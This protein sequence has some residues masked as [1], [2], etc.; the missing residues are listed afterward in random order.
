MEASYGHVRDLPDGA[1]DVPKDLRDQEWAALGVDVANG[2]KPLYVVSPEKQKRVAALK[3]A[4][5][6]CDAL[7]LAT[8]GD[9]E[10]EAIA[11]HLVELLQPKVPVYRLVFHEITRTAIE[12]ALKNA[13]SIDADLVHAQETRRIVDRLVGYKVSPLLWHKIAYGLSAGRVQ[14]VALRLPDNRVTRQPGMLG[15]VLENAVQCS[16]S[17]RIMVRHGDVMLTAGLRG[18]PE[19]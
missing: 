7:Y 8:D 12:V 1:E 13:R 16:R 3:Q 10:G 17:Q 18:Q 19:M 15:D 14:S 11:W 6:Q 9:S 5:A 4:L 2:F